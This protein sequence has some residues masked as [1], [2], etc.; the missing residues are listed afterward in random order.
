MGA[1]VSLAP[2]RYVVLLTAAIFFAPGSALGSLLVAPYLGLTEQTALNVGWGVGLLGCWAGSLF[3]TIGMLKHD[4]PIAKM[5][6]IFAGAVTLTVLLPIIG[7]F[8]GYLALR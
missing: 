7:A 3:L 6:R 2:L 4:P 1:A 5:D 8:L